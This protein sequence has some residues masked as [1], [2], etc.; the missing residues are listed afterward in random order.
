MYEVASHHEVAGR[1]QRAE[2]Q[3]NLEKMAN[4]KQI[5]ICSLA[6]G[7]FTLKVDGEKVTRPFNNLVEAVSFAYSAP[8]CRG[9]IIKVLDTEGKLS[10]RGFL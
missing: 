10:F 3:A 6:E 9:A 2:R 7:H 8:E 5:V 4:A 1:P